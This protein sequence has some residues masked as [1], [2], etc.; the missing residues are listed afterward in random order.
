MQT[1]FEFLI[2]GDI[3]HSGGAPV[4]FSLR[5]YLLD[6][7]MRQE[8]APLGGR[9][10]PVMCRASTTARVQMRL[11]SQSKLAISIVGLPIS[12]VLI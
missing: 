4:A 2:N 7:E 12:K 9:E 11:R 3:H 8:K 1:D 10:V 5:D 6:H